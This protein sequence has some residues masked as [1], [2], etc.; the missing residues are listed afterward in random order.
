MSRSLVGRSR[1]CA[2][3]IEDNGVSGEH[4]LISYTGLGWEVR[5]LGSKNGTFVE[6]V[7]LEAGKPVALAE[8]SALGF[9]AKDGWSL[10][11]DTP[12]VLMAVDLTTAELIPASD[13][14]LALPSD[15]NPLVSIYPTSHGDYVLE[16]EAGESRRLAEAEVISVG[17]R[18]FRVESPETAEGTPFVGEGPSLDNVTLRFQVSRNEEYVDLVVLHR[19]REIPLARREH[20]Y[21]LLTL[22]RVRLADSALPPEERG[23]VDREEL[24]R[25]LNMETNALDVAIHR[26]R[27]QLARAG[28]ERAAGVVEVRPGQRRI[29]TD[30]LEIR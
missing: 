21:V 8:G 22:A 17:G 20:L 14:V 16:S 19:G 12:P 29:C 4:A 7:R 25:M 28:V 15:D 13:G 27:K 3:R 10:V 5:D 24:L 1:S 23:W 9:G 26:A 30:R 11:D 6:G 2:L 18:V